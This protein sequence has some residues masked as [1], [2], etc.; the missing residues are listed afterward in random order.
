MAFENK[1]PFVE[2]FTIGGTE[3]QGG[4]QP[5]SKYI[6]GLSPP[7]YDAEQTNY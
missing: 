2:K 3:G 1:S 5:L 7:T 4:L 6:W